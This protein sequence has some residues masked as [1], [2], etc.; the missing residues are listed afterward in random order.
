MLLS[1][2]FSNATYRISSDKRTRSNKLPS[3]NKRPPLG[4][5]IKQAPLSN[6]A[7]RPQLPSLSQIVEM[8][9]ERGNLHIIGEDNLEETRFTIF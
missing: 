2:F 3:P 7:P 9:N 4:H 6:K 5:S 1:P 8:Q